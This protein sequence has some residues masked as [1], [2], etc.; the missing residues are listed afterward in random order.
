MVLLD[1]TTLREIA[2]VAASPAGRVVNPA[3]TPDGSTL[4]FAASEGDGPFQLR[5]VDLGP[6]G[7]V[8]A[9]RTVFTAPG[10]A[11]APLPMRDGRMVFVG[12]T[13]A[14]HDLFAVDGL[15]IRSP[16]DERLRT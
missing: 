16:G 11:Q 7:R 1:G 15:T 6:G 10:G 12:Y 4:V 9:A 14:G 13:G 3:F 8:T 5:A 2:S